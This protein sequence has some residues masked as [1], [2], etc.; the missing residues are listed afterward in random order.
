MSDRNSQLESLSSQ[1]AH[2]GDLL[3]QL[4]D[5]LQQE[6]Q[7]LSDK[8]LDK[9]T[10]A[11]ELKKSILDEFDTAVSDRMETLSNLGLDLEHQP[12]PEIK[13]FIQ[14]C[15]KENSEIEQHWK[16]L[17]ELLEQCKEQN[18]I[19]G[20]VIEVSSQSLQ[21]AYSLLTAPISGETNLYNAKG[22][23]R[24]GGGGSGKSLAKA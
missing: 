1:L 7:C 6:H 8:D 10:A 24:K 13:K 3:R 2:E 15:A 9:L 21:T 16:A 11:V 20:A 14:T 12:Q 18:T 5:G 17:E 19:N 23:S 22:I 4:F